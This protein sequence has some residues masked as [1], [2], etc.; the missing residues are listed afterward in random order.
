[1]KA[2]VR[3]KAPDGIFCGMWFIELWDKEYGWVTSKYWMVKDKEWVH[4][5]IICEIAHLT[6]LGYE[7]EYRNTNYTNGG[8]DI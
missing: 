4:D 2:R 1:M 5:S 8:N 7:I 3:W 6:E